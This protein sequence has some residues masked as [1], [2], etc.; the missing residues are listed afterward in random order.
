MAQSHLTKEE[1]RH[2]VVQDT[3]LESVDYLQRHLKAVIMIAVAAV[4]IVAAGV[5]YYAYLQHTAREQSAAY[6]TAE[7]LLATP[8]VALDERIKQTEAAMEAFLKANPNARLAP[9]AYGYLAR[10]AFDRKDY[11][12]AEDAYT[13][14]LNHSQ[15]DAVQRAI[16]LLSLGKLKAAQGKPADGVQFF[17]QI[18]DKR[19]EDAKAYAVGTANLASGKPEDARKQFQQAAAAQPSTSVSTWA[20]DALDYL[21]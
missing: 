14:A 16:V 3:L 13:K 8:N 5:A 4:V 1:L 17:N 10:F 18:S 21:P 19:F 6:Y 15:T 20:K 12:K 7:K 2:D 9:A 11:A